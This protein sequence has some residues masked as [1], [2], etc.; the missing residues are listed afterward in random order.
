MDR[1]VVEEVEVVLLVGGGRGGGGGGAGGDNQCGLCAA[2]GA[3]EGHHAHHMP[4]A[5]LPKGVGQVGAGLEGDTCD[6]MSHRS[7]SPLTLPVTPSHQQAQQRA[8]HSMFT[9]LQLLAA[10]RRAARP[11]LCLRPKPPTHAATHAR[12][13]AQR[14]AHHA[15]T[16]TGAA[17]TP[18]WRPRWR[19][20]LG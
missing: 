4:G 5:A 10:P 13:P 3:G 12:M 11:L 18:P 8:P 19:G 9:T 6:M 14:A 2:A 16:R 17:P 20:R 7:A 15:T 1:L